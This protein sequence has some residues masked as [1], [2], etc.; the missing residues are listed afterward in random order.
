MARIVLGI[1]SSHTPMLN[2]RADQWSHRANV[3]YENKKL[4]LSDGRRVTYPQL[5]EERGP[6]YQDDIALPVLQRKEKACQAALDR[7]ADAI[8]AARP[9]VVV[10]IGDDQGELFDANNQPAFAIY[11]GDEIVTTPGKYAE[12]APDWMR[13]VGRG[14]L[15]EDV[16]RLPGSPQL[17]VRLIEGLVDRDVDVSAVAGVKDPLQAGFGHAYGFIAKRMF[18]RE[19]P[20]LPVLLNTYFPPNVPTAARAYDVGRK[21]REVIESFPEDLRIAVVASGG[22]SHFVVDEDFDRMVIDA[23]RTKDVATLRALPRRTLKSGSSETLNWIM[24]AGAVD[25]M[26]LQWAEY[27]PLIRTAAGTGTGAAFCVWSR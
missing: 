18:R 5:L 22:L 17:A 21:L 9:D 7:L 11:H 8:D 16:H 14:Y 2:L 24:T 19:I 12:G 3:D 1:G 20:M 25:F 23:L 15:M 6:R 13:Q 26:D 27:Q 4:N 10:V